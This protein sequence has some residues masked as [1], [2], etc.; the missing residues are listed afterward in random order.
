[1][2]VGELGN[3][4]DGAK[5]GPLGA[6]I[7]AAVL[8]VLSGGDIVLPRAVVAAAKLALVP[9]SL[10]DYRRGRD[11]AVATAAALVFGAALVIGWR[12]AGLP[13]AECL[14]QPL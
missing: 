11:G 7:Q 4:D 10:D 2:P 9:A 3:L 13:I 14:S 12:R 8:V 1:M 5:G 6:L